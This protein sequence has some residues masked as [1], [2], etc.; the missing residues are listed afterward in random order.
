MSN[1]DETYQNSDLCQKCAKCCKTMWFWT[2]EFDDFLR[3]SWL[4]TDLITV[5]SVPST[6]DDTWRVILHIPCK[7]LVEH[8]DGT[9]SCGVYD[10]VRPSYCRT[11]PNNFLTEYM[12]EKYPEFLRDQAETFCPALKQL[13]G[14]EEEEPPQ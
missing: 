9:W 13:M 10:R 6:G 14:R 8:D 4:D 1:P 7:H 5:E 11:Y 12:K 3:Y 2:H